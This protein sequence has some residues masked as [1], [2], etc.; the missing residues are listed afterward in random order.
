MGIDGMD[1][2]DGSR[3]GR[4]DIQR[5]LM[6]VGGISG[7]LLAMFL[8]TQDDGGSASLSSVTTNGGIKVT[9]EVMIDPNVLQPAIHP[10]PRPRPIR[11]TEEIIDSS[12]EDDDRWDAIQNHIQSIHDKV[13]T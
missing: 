3:Q 2:S 10:L 1:S 9:Y 5:M 8:E 12:E 11:P 13:E 6:S 7:R 4:A